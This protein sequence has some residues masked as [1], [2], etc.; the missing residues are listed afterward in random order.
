MGYTG[1]G[2]LKGSAGSPPQ[3]GCEVAGGVGGRGGMRVGGG[4]DSWV[5]QY[6]QRG[7]GGWG[8]L[9]EAMYGGP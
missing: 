5:I 1:T 9:D 2:R 3:E 4:G 7:L 8:R 6:P